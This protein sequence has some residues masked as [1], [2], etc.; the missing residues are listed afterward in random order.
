MGNNQGL[1]L[2]IAQYPYTMDH[3][4]TDLGLQNKIL[5]GSSGQVYWTVG[6]NHN[7]DIMIPKAS[8]C[9]GPQFVVL[10]KDN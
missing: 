10:L 3:E 6:D 4:L 8:I 5:K 1:Q 2:Q 9:W 7:C